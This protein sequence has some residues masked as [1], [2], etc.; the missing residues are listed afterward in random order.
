MHFIY[1]YVIMAL[2]LF[3]EEEVNARALRRERVFRDRSNPL[4]IYSDEEIIRKY[5]LPRELILNLIDEL[6]ERLEPKTH[7]NK[8]IPTHLQILMTLKVLSS[9]TFQE[10]VG[11]GHGVHKLTISR[12]MH[13]VCQAIVAVY[14]QRMITFP[15]TPQ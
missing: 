6:R 10:V 14:K 13:K 7:R 2:Y 12:K 4:E 3:V 9:G 1:I 11:D 8:S 5:R 15:T